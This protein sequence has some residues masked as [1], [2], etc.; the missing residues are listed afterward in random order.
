LKRI[1]ITSTNL[2]FFRTLPV[3]DMR[4]GA[5]EEIPLGDPRFAEIVQALRYEGDAFLERARFHANPDGSLS[6]QMNRITGFQQG[7]HDL[8]MSYAAFLLAMEMRKRLL[9][10]LRAPEM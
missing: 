5:G 4:S 3:Q 6:E 2:P 7:A 10:L 9:A 1:V 8:S